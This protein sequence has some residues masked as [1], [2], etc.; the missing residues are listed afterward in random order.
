MIHDAG[1][2]TIGRNVW[3]ITPARG[4]PVVYVIAA[5]ARAAADWYRT[6]VDPSEI[7]EIVVQD[8]GS[9]D[10]T[11]VLVWRDETRLDPTTTDTPDPGGA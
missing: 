7:N 4:G 8:R 5:N 9:A 10:R 2:G 1:D 3:Q 6:L 11:E